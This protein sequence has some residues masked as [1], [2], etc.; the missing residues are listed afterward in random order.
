LAAH[1]VTAVYFG[2]DLL[3]GSNIVPEWDELARMI[4]P[5]VDVLR[6]SALGHIANAT[7]DATL[8]TAHFYCM[9]KAADKSPA[10]TL[11]KN[12]IEAMPG[13]G[14]Y[15]MQYI[16][17][18]KTRITFPVDPASARIFNTVMANIGQSIDWMRNDPTFD[19]G[20]A[21][22][23]EAVVDWINRKGGIG[24]L[25]KLW[26]KGSTA[27]NADRKNEEKAAILAGIR[28]RELDVAQATTDPRTGEKFKTAEDHKAWK[29]E[30][31]AAKNEVILRSRCEEV[32]DGLI[33]RAIA[34]DHPPARRLLITDNAGQVL[35]LSEED[36]YLLLRCMASAV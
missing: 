22:P 12:M 13:A 29:A 28:A 2:V 19:L 33:A 18:L 23:V 5:G 7:A 10:G 11:F 14:N 20:P 16:R 21:M 4:Q 3:A 15:G 35:L 30:Q 25:A 34:T 24:T 26:E 1:D 17:W 9:L 31:E 6:D 32:K 36:E 8:A 27:R